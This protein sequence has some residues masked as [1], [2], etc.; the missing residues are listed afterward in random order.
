V[1][2][3]MKT[4]SA[5]NIRKYTLIGNLIENENLA[6]SPFPQLLSQ[7]QRRLKKPQHLP[8]VMP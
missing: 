5:V 3:E 4:V 2:L 1:P 6:A 7:N 8:E